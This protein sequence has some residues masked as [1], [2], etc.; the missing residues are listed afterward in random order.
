VRRVPRWLAVVAATVC[1]VIGF[2][3]S[4]AHAAVT[5]A[6]HF[7]FVKNYHDPTNSRLTF[8]VLRID[9][10]RP[11]TVLSASWRAGSG[12][13]T[14]D[15]CVRNHGWIPNGTYNVFAWKNHTGI[16][17]GHAFQLNDTR[18]YNGTPRTEL[19]IHTSYPWSTARY[20]SE[21]CVKVDNADIDAAYNDFTAFFA[22]NHWYN[23]MLT[24]Q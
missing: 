1:A 21:G 16:I 3:V 22:I 14:E 11:R 17:T 13:G 7:T 19:F 18:C 6:G 2:G 20:H 24:V 5:F 15:G 23:A 12:D 10:D 8:M 4:P 9:P